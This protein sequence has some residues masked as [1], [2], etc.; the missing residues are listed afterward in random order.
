[1][2]IGKNIKTVHLW[3]LL[4]FAAMQ[5]GIFM[6]YWPDFVNKNWGVHVHYWTG[7]LWFVF[8]ILQPFLI[9]KGNIDAHHLYGLLGLFV[10]GGVVFSALTLYEHDIRSAFNAEA[11]GDELTARFFTGGIMMQNV[12]MSGFLWMLIASMWYRKKMEEHGW[13]L[14]MSGFCV[15]LPAVGRGVFRFLAY[16]FGGYENFNPVLGSII[17]SLIIGGLAALLAWRFNKWKHPATWVAIVITG[18]AYWVYQAAAMND[19]VYHS[20]KEFIVI[21]K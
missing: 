16:V 17:T 7:T 4:P 8:I 13:Y 6:D 9:A 21:D 20:M 18:V 11:E 2:S 12:L 14:M 1:M 3:M 10:A 19:W 5:I 15:M